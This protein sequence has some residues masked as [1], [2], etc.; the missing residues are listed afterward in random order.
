MKRNDLAS[1]TIKLVFESINMGFLRASDSIPRIL[2]LVSSKSYGDIHK[3]F[4]KY[5]RD[6][7]AWIFL[8]WINQLIAIVNRP[9]VAVI[10]T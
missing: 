7:P 6:T 1:L 2:E 10:E 9:E 8:R 5:T 4:Q 3:A